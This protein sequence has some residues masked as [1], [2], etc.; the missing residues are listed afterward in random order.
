MSMHKKVCRK[1]MFYCY[2]TMD[3]GLIMDFIMDEAKSAQIKISTRVL[4]TLLQKQ[5]QFQNMHTYSLL[6]SILKQKY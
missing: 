1:G 5:S 3:Y 6:L 4:L 2:F